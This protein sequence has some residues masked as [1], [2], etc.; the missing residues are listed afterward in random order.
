V[1]GDHLDRLLRRGGHRGAVLRLLTA[2]FVAAEEPV[3]QGVVA[4]GA[5]RVVGEGEGVAAVL[6]QFDHLAQEGVVGRGR[7]E[8]RQAHHL[9]LVVVG[10]EAEV[11]GDLPEEQGD[12]MNVAGPGAVARTRTAP[13][14]PV[15]VPRAPRETC[16]A[17][18]DARAGAR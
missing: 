5:A 9:V 16:R 8:G 10:H 2:P 13:V 11:T 6:V 18:F 4:A 12:T 7:R 3:E 14:R 17:A 15:P 1:R